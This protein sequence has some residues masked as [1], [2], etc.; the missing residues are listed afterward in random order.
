MST[1]SHYPR[2]RSKPAQIKRVRNANKVVNTKVIKVSP[3][4]MIINLKKKLGQT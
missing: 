3:N 1:L 4:I 2:N